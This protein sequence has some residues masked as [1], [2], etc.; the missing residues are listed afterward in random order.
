MKI[1]LFALLFLIFLPTGVYA[2]EPV[3][4]S[5]AGVVIDFDTGEILFEQN[6][7]IQRPPAS[8]AKVMTAFIVY[9]EIAAGNMSLQTLIPISHN[10]A[11]VSSSAEYQG[12][13]V[14]LRAGSEHTVETLMYLTFLPSSNGAPVAFAEFISGSEEAFVERM[15]QTAVE[16]GIRATFQNSHGAVDGRDLMDAIGIAV[17][18]AVFIE[19]HPDILRISKATTYDF[20]GRTFR[21]T[22]LLLTARPFAGAD[23]F[24]TG[25]TNRAGRNL[26]ATAE[27]NGRRVVAV[28]MGAPSQEARYTDIINLMEFGFIEA[29]RRDDWRAM[30]ENER[31]EILR[32]EAEWEAALQREILASRIRVFIDGEEVPYSTEFHRIMYGTAVAAASPFFRALGVSYLIEENGNI[33]VKTDEGRDVL[34]LSG[35]DLIF[36]EGR[37]YESFAPRTVGDEIFVPI[38]FALDALGSYD[39]VWH[40]EANTIFISSAYYEFDEEAAFEMVVIYDVFDDLYAAS[41]FDVRFFSTWMT[42]IFAGGAVGCFLAASGKHIFL[43]AVEV[44][45][46]FPGGFSGKESKQSPAPGIIFEEANRLKELRLKS[47]RRRR[48]AG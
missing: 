38:R 1:F 47:R 7:D 21:N 32:L 12:N 5:H 31:L 46:K 44:A 48:L 29:A 42:V 2:N 39:M 23:G 11:R 35:Q 27:R 30:A 8:I 20:A 40:G 34:F 3:I 10:A 13:I 19:R 33:L 45:K 16:L 37:F 41:V 6:A 25:T 9:E 22:N 14:P 24:K 26:V 15:N 18:T 36:A 28:Q 17:L 4:R 43:W